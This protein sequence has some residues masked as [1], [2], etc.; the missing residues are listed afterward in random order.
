ML[1]TLLATFPNNHQIALRLESR[2]RQTMDS[3]L[4]ASGYTASLPDTRVASRYTFGKTMDTACSKATVKRLLDWCERVIAAGD[5][6]FDVWIKVLPDEPIDAQDFIGRMLYCY[7][8]E[9]WHQDACRPPMPVRAVQQLVTD[10]LCGIGSFSKNLL[11][12]N[13][14]HL[15]L[16]TPESCTPLR[17]APLRELHACETCTPA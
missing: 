9:R 10:L 12:R 2:F 17:A 15:Q 7:S 11:F 8:L 6:S 16:L 3:T 13:A 4:Q 1:R 5:R 14:F